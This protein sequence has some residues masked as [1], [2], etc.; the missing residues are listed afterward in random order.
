MS[1]TPPRRARRPS[2]PPHGLVWPAAAECGRHFLKPRLTRGGS[3]DF[4]FTFVSMAYIGLGIA[5][6]VL[7]AQYPTVICGFKGAPPLR[8]WIFGTGIAYIIIGVIL[9]AIWFLI[10]KV[11]KVHKLC[12]VLSYVIKLF[13]FAWVREMGGSAGIGREVLTRGRP[14]R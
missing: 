2:A 6:L 13:C 1:L 3:Q 4:F 8:Q 10:W 14:R 9:V 7:T 12:I 11:D 5:S